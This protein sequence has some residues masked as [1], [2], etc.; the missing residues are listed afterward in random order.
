MSALKKKKK[1]PKHLSHSRPGRTK[2]DVTAVHRLCS[3]GKLVERCVCT[4]CAA[5][6][7]THP[8]GRSPASS[9]HSGPQP[10]PVPQRAVCQHLIN[11]WDNRSLKFPFN[12][13]V[14]SNNQGRDWM[15]PNQR[16]ARWEQEPLIS[17]GE[18][19]AFIR[20]CTLNNT[21]AVKTTQL[22]I[23]WCFFFTS[24][25]IEFQDACAVKIS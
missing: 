5:Q 17:I 20:R 19:V 10:C 1:A 22:Q 2:D 12:Q 7:L 24:V 8:S 16:G 25:G 6:P 11:T 4:L 15:N 18:S 21:V 13:W 9:V 14:Q 3:R 23:W